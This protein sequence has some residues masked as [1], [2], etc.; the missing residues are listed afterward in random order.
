MLVLAGM[1]LGPLVYNIR[2]AH[3]MTRHLAVRRLLPDSATA[4]EP[5][6]VELVVNSKNR[7]AGL[8][9]IDTIERQ[10]ASFLSLHTKVST[11]IAPSAAGGT[12]AVRY[13]L[14]L[15]RRGEYHFGPLQVKTSYPFGLIRCTIEHDLPGA[16]LVFPRL[17]VLTAAWTALFQQAAHGAQRQRR[18]SYAAGDFYGLRDYRSGDSRRHIHWRTS[19]RRGNLMVRQFERALHQDVAIYLDLWQPAQPTE[20][21]REHVERAVSFADTLVHLLCRRGGCHIWI[22][23]AGAAQTPLEGVASSA[24]SREAM[25]R[26]ARAEASGRNSDQERDLAAFALAPRRAT[27]VVLTTRAS[28]TQAIPSSPAGADSGD[29]PLQGRLVTISTRQGAFDELFHFDGPPADA[30]VDGAHC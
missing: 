24:L 27:R 4:G 9:L 17:G 5:L 12:A 2:V 30:R 29:H 28:I 8:R 7:S 13:R 26:L 25:A 19:A 6:T 16:L 23:M 10:A 20:S 18:Q 11:S 3:R 1:M 22:S 21:D 14:V 15:A